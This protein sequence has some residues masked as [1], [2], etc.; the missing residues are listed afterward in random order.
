MKYRIFAIPALF[1]LLLALNSCIKD[2]NETSYKEW[3][4]ENTTFIEDAATER[5]DGILKYE[6]VIPD[7]D[8][9]VYTLMQ[10]HN[11][12]SL[13]LPNGLRPLSNS[14][15][16]VKY[17]LTNIKGDTLDSSSSF[18]CK[19][20]NL[21]TGFWVAVTNMQVGDSVTAIIPHEAGYGSMGSGK[22]LPYS[23]LIFNIKLDSIVAF[24]S[25]PWRN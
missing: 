6:K 14:T 10:W 21:I 20:N 1:S 11:D 17:L 22:V 7:W 4:M 8:K 13:T 18:R 5:V 3:R 19:P 15:I 9:S 23:T 25:Q 16:D 24:D 12:R 2:G